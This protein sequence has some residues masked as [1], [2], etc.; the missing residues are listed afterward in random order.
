MADALLTR[1]QSISRILMGKTTVRSII[2]KFV[3]HLGSFFSLANMSN[4]AVQACLLL[5]LFFD[6]WHFF[7]C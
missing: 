6:I 7:C 2:I 4:L 3:R 1:N 5:L